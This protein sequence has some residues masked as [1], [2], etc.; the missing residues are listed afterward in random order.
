MRVVLDCRMASWSGVGRYTR[1]LARALARRDD[2]DLIQVVGRGQEPPAD[3]PKIRMVGHPLSPW[4][5]VALGGA[6]SAA[7]PDITHCPHYPTPFPV[8][9]PLVVTLHDLTPLVIP[10]VMES[11]LRRSV[12][13]RMNAR[14]VRFADRILTVSEYTAGDVSRIFPVSADKIR[15]TPNAVDDFTS[16]PVGSLPSWLGGQRYLFSMGNT[17]AHKDLPTL[18]R[19]FASIAAEH[20]DLLLVLAGEDPGGYAASILG[21]SPATS[22]VRFTGPLDDATLRA[23]YAGALAFAFP[24][25]YEGFGLPP[26]E[27]MALGTPVVTT[28]AASLPEV[29]GCAALTFSPGDVAAL[30]DILRLLVTDV[31]ARERLTA[32]GR[33]R[34]A[35]FSWDHTAELTVA[36]YTEVVRSR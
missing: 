29:V 8:E 10:G 16:G 35:L 22:R 33:A 26:L 11:A 18:L 1:G 13:R 12:Y 27:A 24:S 7:R 34:A 9:H 36:V 4:G 2:V 3:A 30:A 17:K 15:V 5:A 28:D 25:T 32:A 6:V 14:A 20:P 19:A 21:D 31:A 23:L